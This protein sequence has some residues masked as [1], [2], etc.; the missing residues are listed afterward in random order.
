MRTVYIRGAVSGLPEVCAVWTVSPLMREVLIRLAGSP[1][2]EG[3]D[4]LVA[5]LLLE[6][7]TSSARPFHLP[8]PADP[9]L[10]RLADALCTE[11]ST[12]T[13]LRDWAPRLGLSE[14]NL[15]RRFR[16]ETGMTFRQWR[17][18]VRVLAA[19]EQL[20]AGSPVTTV[21]FAVGYE[22]V[23]AF[24]AAFHD[25]FGEPPGR[26]LRSGASR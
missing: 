9:R 19:L 16:A 5:L 26:Y 24:V 1:V 3:R 2:P 17:R 7:E 25:T 11:P 8:L 13:P 6:I 12:S 4:H 14:R 15:I 23:S 10:R 22:S 21:A 18:Q 20:A